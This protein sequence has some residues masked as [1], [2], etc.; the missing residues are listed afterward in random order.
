VPV[1]QQVGGQQQEHADDR[2]ADA[3]RLLVPVVPDRDQD[4][5]GG[6]LPEADVDSDH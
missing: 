4:E 6:D 3:Q 5:R 2:E 1:I